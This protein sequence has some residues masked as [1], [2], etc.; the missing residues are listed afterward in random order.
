MRKPFVRP[1]VV[2]SYY[3][4]MNCKQIIIIF[5]KKRGK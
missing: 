3:H 4:R 1:G 2:R 5:F